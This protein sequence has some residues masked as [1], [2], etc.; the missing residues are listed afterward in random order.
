MPTP[1]TKIPSNILKNEVDCCA[2]ALLPCGSSPD[3][4]HVISPSI[5]NGTQDLSAN[6]V[7]NPHSQ[8]SEPEAGGDAEASARQL[9]LDMCNASA[10]DYECIF[11]SGATGEHYF[12]VATGSD[13]HPHFF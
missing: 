11:T 9:T 6:V 12:G 10:S 7:G 2:S 8:H 4:F 13:L 1:Q 3:T 5:S